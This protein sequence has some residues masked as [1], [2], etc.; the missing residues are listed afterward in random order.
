MNH[1]ETCIHRESGLCADCQAEYDTDPEAWIEFGYH[2]Q[3]QLN[4]EAEKKLIEQ[5]ARESTER[6]LPDPDLPF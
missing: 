5:S 3:G 2:T 1:W 4:W 6:Q